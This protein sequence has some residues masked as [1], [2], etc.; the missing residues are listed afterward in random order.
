M[1][2]FAF[3]PICLPSL[4]Q[5]FDGLD[6]IVAGEISFMPCQLLQPVRCASLKSTSQSA[7]L[8]R[9]SKDLFNHL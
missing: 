3:P 4:G 9:S 5:S 8:C 6:G 7:N 2:L 1:D